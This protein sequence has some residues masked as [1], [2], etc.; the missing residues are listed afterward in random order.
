VATGGGNL[1]SDSAAIRA[2]IA[3]VGFEKLQRVV[4]EVRLKQLFFPSPSLE[5]RVN[6]GVLGEFN[7]GDESTSTLSVVTVAIPPAF[8]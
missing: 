5:N 8:R 6:G 3:F 1:D 2:L 7:P 4:L